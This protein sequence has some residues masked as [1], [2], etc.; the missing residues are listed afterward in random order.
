MG[1]ERVIKLIDF[2]YL[3]IGFFCKDEYDHYSI[4]NSWIW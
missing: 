1:P 2:L 3:D 4:L